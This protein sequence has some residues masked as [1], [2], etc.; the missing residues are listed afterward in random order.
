MEKEHCFPYLMHCW[1]DRPTLSMTHLRLPILHCVQDLEIFIAR[2]LSE[3]SKRDEASP[4]AALAS[5]R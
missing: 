3:I 1:Q 5:L 2:T 4:T